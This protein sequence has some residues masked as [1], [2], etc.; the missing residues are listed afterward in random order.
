MSGE[1]LDQAVACSNFLSAQYQDPNKLVVEVNGILDELKFKEGTSNIFEEAFKRIC[2][3]LG[4]T[5]QRPELE[6]KKGP[7]VLWRIGANQYL[8]IECKNEATSS[9]ISKDYCNQLNGSCNWFEEKY[10]N[11]CSYVPFMV[12]PSN[13]FEYAAS[14]KG[15]IR[16]INQDK[17]EEFCKSVQAF[18]TS[19]ASTNQLA[20]AAEIRSKLIAYR[21]RASDLADNYTIPYKVKNQI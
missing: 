21:L 7:D 4:F 1:I 20:N 13:L 17:L 14:P 5:G 18:I 9:T 3:Y 8:V 15:T 10:G 19:V 12:H 16:I 2:H 6:Y 11:E